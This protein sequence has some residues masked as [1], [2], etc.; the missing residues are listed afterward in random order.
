MVKDANGME[1][2]E[3]K[4]FLSPHYPADNKLFLFKAKTSAPLQG[5]MPP[6]LDF[7]AVGNTMERLFG[8]IAGA[9]AKAG[10]ELLK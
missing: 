8:L 10:E 3:R 1:V 6:T 2:V 4:L 9:K 5:G 7:P